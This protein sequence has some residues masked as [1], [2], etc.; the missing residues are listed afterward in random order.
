MP[1]LE[2]LK[3]THGALFRQFEPPESPGIADLILREVWGSYWFLIATP[4]VWPEVSPTPGDEE[5]LHLCG[6]G[7][8]WGFTGMLFKAS[9][10]VCRGPL[11][12]KSTPL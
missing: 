12:P 2:R 9:L 7:P 10:G 6:G 1:R 4:V 8:L 3:I 5:W 11:P